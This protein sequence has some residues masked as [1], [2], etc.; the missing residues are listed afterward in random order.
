M[1]VALRWAAQEE[2]IDSVANANTCPLARLKKPH[3]V[4]ALLPGIGKT[5]VAHQPKGVVGVISPWNYPMTLTA[6]DSVPALL[7]GNAVVLKPIARTP[8]CALACAELLYQAGLPRGLYAVVPG[9]GSVVGTAITDN[10]DY[11]MFTGSSATGIQ[12]AEHVG[13]LIGFSAELGGKNAMIASAV[14]I[15]TRWR[16][17]LPGP[18]SPTLASCASRLNGSTSK[19]ALLR[20]SPESSALRCET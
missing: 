4:Q 9:P 14:P 1:A 12:L 10:C 16:R 19:K 6:S 8:Y 11:L 20:N 15:S 5:T 17:P 13:R 3:K 2:V 7:A 18:A